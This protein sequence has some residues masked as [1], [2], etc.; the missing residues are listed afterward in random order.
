MRTSN[1]Q[2]VDLR[3]ADP[4]AAAAYAERGQRQDYLQRREAARAAQAAPF[5]VSLE[6]SI[7]M[8]DGTQRGSLEPVEESEFHA[9]V[10]RRL[11]A[12]GLITERYG[13]A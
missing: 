3:Y 11:L 5:V 7:K 12:D 2:V 10:W 1:V 4:P 13:A 6:C 8:P 9:R